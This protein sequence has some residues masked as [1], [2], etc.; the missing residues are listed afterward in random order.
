MMKSGKSVMVQVIILITIIIFNGCTESVSEDGVGLND[1]ISTDNIQHQDLEQ[2]D[3]IQNESQEQIDNTESSRLEETEIYITRDELEELGIP[4]NMLAYW[5]VLNSK[6]P[7]ISANEGC[8]EFFWDEF[9]W[10][11]SE[12]NLMYT[13]SQFG[14]VDLDNDGSEELVMTGFPEMTQILD[15]Q[16]GKVYGYQFVFRGMARINIDGVYSSSSGS[17]IGGFHKIHLDKGSYEEETMAYM[18]SNYFEV[19]GVEVSSDEFYAYTASL[20][21]TEMMVEMDFREEILDKTLLGDLDEGI[22]LGMRNMKPEEIC[23]ENNPQMVDVPKAYRAVLTGSEEFVCVTEDGEKFLVDGDYVRNS[24]GEDQYQILYFSSVDME[25]DGEDEVVLTCSGKNLILHEAEGIIYGYVFDCWGEMNVIANDGV[26]QTGSRSED[27]Y[28]K[29]VSFNVD[30]C[31]IKEVDYNGNINDNRIRY[32]YFSKELIER[33][34][35][36]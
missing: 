17:D 6:M 27:Q 36:T 32:Y 22:L 13:T 21:E 14:L 3:H 16:D 28:G 20:M 12:P 30:G 33:Y 5:L 10:C 11:L 4:E 26:F 7:F 9:F 8:Q 25:R 19:G 2:V 23:D 35:G 31:E 29:I 18:D 1:N 24:T 34:L 15:Y